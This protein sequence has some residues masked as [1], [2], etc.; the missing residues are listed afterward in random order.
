MTHN[1]IMLDE[2]TSPAVV[3]QLET[4]EIQVWRLILTDAAGVRAECRHILSIDEQAQADRRLPGR[5]RDEFVYGRACLRILLSENLGTSASYVPIVST[6]Y[7]KPHVSGESAL[8]FNVS[9]SHGIVLISLSR[10][11]SVG[12]DVERMNPLMEVMELAPMVFSS[13]AMNRLSSLSTEA[14]KQYF[15]YRTWTRKEAVVKADGRGLSL[16][17]TGFDLPDGPI[18]NQPVRMSGKLYCLNDIGVGEGYLSA[19]AT[20]SHNCRISMHDFPVS[21]FANVPVKE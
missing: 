14:E 19:L 6:E 7:G 5:V 16:P 1:S 3:R 17:L 4:N 10:Q 20:E 13:G 2:W 8:E 18:S 12:M 15:F 21:V 11:G 9:H